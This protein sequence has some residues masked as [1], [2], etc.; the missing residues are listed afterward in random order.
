MSASQRNTL[1]YHQQFTSI[2][3]TSKHPNLQP[4]HFNNYPLLYNHFLCLLKAHQLNQK[5]LSPETPPLLLKYQPSSAVVA[6]TVPITPTQ[7][8]T[9]ALSS[10]RLWT[11][12]AEA[13]TAAMMTT[14]RMD[15]EATTK[16]LTRNLSLAQHPHRLWDSGGEGV[17]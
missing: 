9:R 5:C 12:A 10:P 15:G 11:S 14:R 4:L 3:F 8:T 6:T 2:H 16:S 7:T 13:T 17:M 1:L